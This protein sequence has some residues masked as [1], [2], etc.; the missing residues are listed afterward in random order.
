VVHEKSQG[1]VLP[2]YG[3]NHSWLGSVGLAVAIAIAYLMAARLGLTLRTKPEGVAF[4]WPAAGI[5]VGALIVL[6]PSARLPGV[7]A[8]AIASA[9]SNLLIGRNI[10]LV[11]T[12]A[13]VNAIQALLTPWLIE[14]WFGRAIKLED[15]SQVL[16]FLTGSAIGAAVVAV[17]AASAVGLV[18]PTVST[19]DVLRL[20][21]VGCLLGIVTV[22]PIV[23]GL[24]EAVRELPPPRELIEGAAGLATL[25]VLCVFVVFLPRGAWTTALPVALAFHLL[26]WLAVRCRPVFS[27]AAALV[28]ALVVIWST[29][30][31]IGPFGDASTLAD[32]ILAAQ[33]F[34]LAGALLTLVLAAL[35]A[36]R[37]R[38][39]TALK[40]SNEQLRD[41]NERLQLALDGAELG[42]F[43]LDITTGHFD[44][45]A[46]AAS[47][48]G[49]S[50]T[51][52]TIKEGRR[53][54]HPDDRARI[55]AAFSGAKRTGGVW[56][57]E[58]RVVHPPSHP[59]AGETRWIAVEGSVL[60][61]AD[62]T[63]MR[64]L[65]VSRDITQRKRAEEA[66]AERN[67]QLALASRAALVGSYAYDVDTERMQISEGY[68]TMHGFP[69]GT[70][71]TTRSAWL[72]RAHPEDI[73]RLDALRRQVFRERRAEQ[74]MV[75]RIVHPNG[76]VRWIESRSFVSYGS[77]GNPQRVVGVNIDVTER[78][79]TEALLR[80]SKARLA[81]AMAA[82]QVMAFEWDAVTGLS[83]RCENAVHILGFE[84]GGR[85]SF[86]LNDFL[87]HV[88]PDDCLNLKTRIRGL[89]PS[90]PS[91]A[92]NF[93]FIR[94]DGREVWL[95]ETAKAEFDTAG[96]LLRIKGLTR[97]VTERKVLEEHKN[98]LIAE[99]DHRVKNVLAIVSVVASRT[100]ETSSSMADFVTAL[101]GRIR[102]MATTHELLSYRR[103]HGIPLAELVQR[104]LAPYATIGNTQI[105]G[106]DD[107]LNAE[108]GQAIA[109]VL[110]EL[111]TNAAKFGALSTTAGRVY[112]RWSHRR[113]GHAHSW[114]SIHWEERG[115]PKVVPPNR[116]GYGTT[117]IR[118]L[119]PYELG[120]TVELVH[121]PGGVRC[122]L[123]IPTHWLSS[124]ASS[125][126]NESVISPLRHTEQPTIPIR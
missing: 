94:L 81:D 47:I 68:A 75:Y 60:Y 13:L 4:F 19:L 108:A 54:V 123:E 117:V 98:L 71:E 29:A 109:M 106:P 70:A 67:L 90:N 124:S 69:E 111:A 43:S 65:G 116:S 87:R 107:V 55:D 82:G 44:C 53:Y 22:A 10:W 59:H 26:L 83:Q 32:R 46:R 119:I 78:Q 2:L 49:H 5:A 40:L 6:G 52:T 110:H 14:R 36:E 48:L 92:L 37:R 73:A 125:S 121:A 97:D 63:P 39:E 3:P 27:A 112:V 8:V 56:N 76:E 20:L 72:A 38:S 35:F 102:S 120:G 50:V 16:G 66:L 31:K 42:A 1:T 30:N 91:Y 45:D 101:D 12:F 93:R 126:F 34:V 25:A 17:G 41:S 77:D 24:V 15:V 103:W 9:A 122:K 80:E 74:S 113:N 118:D 18:E 86:S 33:I 61:S 96:R 100:Q 23:I 64:L 62:G 51:P 104:E 114:L 21:F 79:R 115:G 58:Y 105:E 28:V 57:A 99:L 88:H 84:Q 95:E 11:F 89:R 7:V 85:V